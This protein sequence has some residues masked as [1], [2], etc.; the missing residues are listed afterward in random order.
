MIPQIIL[1][2]FGTFHSLESVDLYAFQLHHA[3]LLLFSG[4]CKAVIH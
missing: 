1:S 3:G 4:K 2:L